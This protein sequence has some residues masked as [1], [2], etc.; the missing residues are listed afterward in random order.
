MSERTLT[1]AEVRERL[2]EI[3]ESL[4]KRI[5]AGEAPP[6]ALDAVYKLIFGEGRGER[7]RIR[8]RAWCASFARRVALEH[9]NP[10]E[11]F[12]GVVATAEQ[13]GVW[14]AWLRQNDPLAEQVLDLACFGGLSVKRIS[15]LIGFAPRVVVRELRR[16]K[17][18]LS[19]RL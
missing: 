3:R 11:P 1:V 12:G 17:E 10:A 15:D 13:V 7:D 16:Q 4:R 14:Y 18:H 6:A 8:F 2:P 5:G 19:V 9:A